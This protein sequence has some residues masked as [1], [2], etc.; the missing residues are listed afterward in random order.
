MATKVV[1]WRERVLA[2][3]GKDGLRGQEIAARGF[4]HVKL[5]IIPNKCATASGY[6][7]NLAK[8]AK[9]MKKTTI[10]NPRN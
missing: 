4:H 10:W 3:P 5:E 2:G 8:N 1:G 9:V 6:E 7:T